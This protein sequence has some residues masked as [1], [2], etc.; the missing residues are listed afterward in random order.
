MIP[1][2]FHRIWLGDRPRPERYDEYWDMWKDLHPSADFITWSED[3]MPILENQAAY[4]FVGRVARSGGVNMSESR[5]VS[6]MRADVMAYELVNQYG[7]VYLN[8]DMMPLKPIDDLL[9]HSAF[10]GM[11]DAHFV[12]NAVMGAEREHPLFQEAVLQLTERLYQNYGAG[13]EVATGPHHLTNVWRNG[14]YDVTILPTT[15][16]YPVHHSQIPYGTKT[17]DSY[18]EI[19]REKGAYAVHMWGHRSQEGSLNR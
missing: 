17:Y 10:L 6:V 2:I 5:A 14:Q 7:G 18:A 13:M 1:R 8:C 11:E 15:A 4:D 9:E 12:C 19:G 16:F 3:N